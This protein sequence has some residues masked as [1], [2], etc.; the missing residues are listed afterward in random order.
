MYNEIIKKLGTSKPELGGMLGWTEDQ[1]V[2]DHFVFDEKAKVTTVEYN[3]DVDFLNEI[4]HN[5][6]DKNSIYLGGFVHSH[7]GSLGTLSY[8][9]V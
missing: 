7:P 1:L 6:W 2:I 8:P 4:L 9:D 5:E 3:P